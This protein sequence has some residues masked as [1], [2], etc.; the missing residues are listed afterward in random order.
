VD[1]RPSDGAEEPVPVLD[2]GKGHL[3]KRAYTALK[4][5]LV[6]GPLV[7]GS[8]LSERQLAKQLGMSNTPVRAALER[9]EAEGFITISPQQGIVVR[10]LSIR[11]IIDHYELREALETF[12]IRKLAGRLTAEQV[13]RVRANLDDQ[14]RSLDARDFERNVALDAEF[15]TLFCGFLGNDQIAR[16]MLQL[17]DKIHRA[18]VSI[19][20]QDL[21]RIME[22]YREHRGIA[23]AVAAGEAER[24]AALLVEHLEAG[25]SSILS[26]RGR[27][28]G[29]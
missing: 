23:D 10:E 5:L 28:H 8:F 3:K 12:V 29:A 17:R 4:G 27:P 2:V 6:S 7:P 13:G 11:E 14:R 19:A 22:S 24:A 1:L 18:I 15:H 16:V 26:P 9:L 20:K 25:R 21:G